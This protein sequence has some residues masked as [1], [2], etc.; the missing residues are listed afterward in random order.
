MD[1]L[2]P[3]SIEQALEM[4]ESVP[5]ARIM[6]GGSDLLVKRRAGLES[7]DA[8]ICLERVPA[9]QGIEQS[10]DRLCIGAATTLTDIL[11]NELI[12]D[13]LSLLHQAAEVF[14]SP[15]VRNMA[16]IGGNICTASPAGD[17]LPPLYVLGAE[18]EIVSTAGIRRLPILD[19][20][21]APGK[22]T[23]AKGE[24]LRAVY[25][26]L[27]VEGLV[28]HYEKVG[29]RKAMAISVVSLA[30]LLDVDDDIITHVRLAWGSVGPTIVRC[31]EAETFL[32]GRQATLETLREAGAMVRRA[33]SPISDIRAGAEYRRQVAANLLLRLAEKCR[34]AP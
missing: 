26:P 25:V 4:L 17:V 29:R 13:K 16:T 32:R 14:A 27:P 15:L 19:F 30:A 33:V 10:E 7:P 11:E 20:I 24:L 2:T 22:T 6:A 12:R 21:T 8:L 3:T 23:L 34:V 9:L 5:G 1:V 31:Q 18:L 28:Q